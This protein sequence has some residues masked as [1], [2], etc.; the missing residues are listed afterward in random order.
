MQETSTIFTVL[1]QSAFVTLYASLLLVVP[2]F[3]IDFFSR[4][5]V[6]RE[7]MSN[8]KNLL[9]YL[10]LSG[11]NY[12][13]WII[14]AFLIYE[15]GFY[16]VHP[17]RTVALVFFA[18]LVTPL[19]ISILISFSYTFG[20]ERWIREK[21]FHVRYIDPIPTAWES[22]L[23]Q[24]D[25]PEWV[26]IQLK[27]G[28]TV[29]GIYSSQSY[30]SS[31][32]AHQDFFLEQVCVFDAKNNAWQFV[33]HSKGM[34][35]PAEQITLIEFWE[36][37]EVTAKKGKKTEGDAESAESKTTGREQVLSYSANQFDIGKLPSGK[38]FRPSDI[39]GDRID[40]HCE[41]LRSIP[42][43]L[44]SIGSVNEKYIYNRLPNAKTPDYL[45]AKSEESGESDG[46]KASGKK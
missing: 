45:Y 19:L 1:S 11:L 34:Y 22:M 21:V 38:S 25:K 31:D 24:K 37:E 29:G 36:A 4:K 10:S 28:N 8:D 43:A 15:S 23:V 35:I 16:L 46:T 27:D 26:M 5:S 42:G 17:L 39:Q 32:L 6:P 44:G 40:M 2:G 41:N 20:W 18:V 7:S 3:L 9:Y 30:G 33:A 12:G 14:P 13:L